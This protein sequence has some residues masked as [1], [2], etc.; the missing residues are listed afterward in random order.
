MSKRPLRE[1]I[2]AFFA[3]LKRDQLGSMYILTAFALPVLVGFGGMGLDVAMWY[4]ERRTTQ[5]IADASA[6]AA[7]YAEMKGGDL[8][9][10]TVAARNEAIRNGYQ[11]IPANTLTVAISTVPAVAATSTPVVDILVRREV[12]IYLL[13]LFLDS[14]PHVAAAST[15]GLRN[16]G[17]NCVIALHDTAPRAI[18]FMGN[19]NSD[20][21]CGVTSNSNSSE[22]LYV[23]G[24]ARL[25]ANP[26]QAYGDIVVSGTGTLIS[27]LP[28]MPFSPKVRDP[29]ENRIFPTVSGACDYA[30]LAVGGSQTIGPSVAG[31]SVR[32]CGNLTVQPSGSLN[33]QPGVYYIDGGS[34]LLRGN[35]QGTDVTLVLTGPTPDSVG[36]IDVRAQASVNLTAP[37]SGEFQ[38]IAIYQDRI[39]DDSGSN[40]LNGG[41]DM[42]IVG[43]VYARSKLLE[44]SG[45]SDVAGCTVLI[46]SQVKFIG[47]TFIK[48]T[49]SLCGTVGLSDSTLPAQQQVVLIR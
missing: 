33:L 39:A 47:D 18:E 15:G 27:A 4:A 7:T 48:N 37:Q 30:G 9:A 23:G 35:I 28:P 32:I 31:G 24:S 14:N 42:R 5:N 17:T 44:Y 34:I 1:K 29:Y 2:S 20:I 26:A 3:S 25:N 22:A 46:A 11:D 49:P 10:M 8:A 6:V 19:A 45:G 38:S 13:G 36:T 43:A 41:S 12:P 21:G 16:L 40:K